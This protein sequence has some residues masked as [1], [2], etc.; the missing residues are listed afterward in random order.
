M[1]SPN[2]AAPRLFGVLMTRNAADLLAVNILRHL[3]TGCERVIVVDN[4]SSDATARILRRLARRHPVDWTID[5][6]SLRQDVIVTGLAHEAFAKGAD[7]VLPLDTDE[8]WHATRPF[9]QILADAAARGAGAL[10]VPRIE[11]IQARD[12]RRSTRSG[13]LRANMRVER[14]LLGNEAVEEFRRGE[15]SIFELAPTAK[16]LVRRSE[17]LQIRRGAHSASGLAGPVEVSQEIV[18]FHVPLRSRSDLE[19]R[20]EHGRRI[21]EVSDD[22]QVSVENRNWAKLAAEE[23]LDEGWRANSYEDG[24]LDVFGRRVELVRDDRLHE[25]LEPWAARPLRRL[26]IKVAGRLR[27]RG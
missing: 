20:G 7:W 22:P 2:V 5:D 13:V 9:D 27:R 26:Q 3:R 19:L 10:E 24:A 18:N 8:F 21:A 14:P 6:G 1:T 4:G 15:R 16:V 23:R 25:L 17:D 12:Q 11:F